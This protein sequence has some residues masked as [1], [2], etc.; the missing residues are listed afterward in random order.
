MPGES[1]SAVCRNPLPTLCH[2][3][4]VGNLSDGELLESFLT[5]PE[6]TA[7]ESFAALVD[8]HGPMVLRL[9]RQVL[10]NPEDAQ[11][12][13]QA[14]F[15]VL[16]QRAGTVRNRDSVASWLYGI[17]LRVARRARVDAARR[18][19]HERR[20][21]ATAREHDMTPEDEPECR[22]PDLHDELGRLPEKYRESVVLCYL[23]GLST[24]AAAQRL[25]C[26]QGTVLSRLSRAREQLRKRLTRRGLIAPA[27][28][29]AAGLATETAKA[30]VPAALARVAIQ[31]AVATVLHQAAGSA[32]ISASAVQL[33][34]GVL[35]TMFYTKLIMAAAVIVTVA[36]LATGAGV[37]LQSISEPGP[38]AIVAARG[39]KPAAQP[40]KDLKK[41]PA[42]R[43]STV[44]PRDLAWSE[45]P[46][47][48]WVQVLDMLAAR[49][50]ANFEKI[51]TWKGT[52]RLLQRV[53]LDK[54]FLASFPMAPKKVEPLIQ[55][56]DFTMSFALD[57]ASGNIYRDR[58]TRGS[59]CLRPGTNEPAKGPDLAPDTRSIVTADQ[60]LEFDPE[61]FV[62]RGSITWPSGYPRPALCCPSP[63]QEGRGRRWH[64]P[65]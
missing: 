62:L 63:C 34:R 41:Y 8:R 5:G 7:Q 3:G 32:A 64:R 47:A 40:P 59:R 54:K 20:C 61:N 29:L 23:Q 12:A 2:V 25:G 10:G 48:E 14:T 53:L 49:S 28:L 24:Q 6:E 44:V 30:A 60:S 11:D 58:E 50:K 57:T 43:D 46:P 65:P 19:V 16:V 38:E 1:V 35:R 56:V 15:L 22:W 51:K 13:F 18:H 4:V 42:L 21:A 27:G 39:P 55:E 31:A 33:T 45:V 26:P 9:C 37:V 36:A 52:Y 17:A